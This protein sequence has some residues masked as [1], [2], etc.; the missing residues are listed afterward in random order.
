MVIALLAKPTVGSTGER[1]E[2]EEGSPKG[3]GNQFPDEDKGYNP[4]VPGKVIYIYR[5]LYIL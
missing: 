2:A 5:S 4:L 1:G 3:D